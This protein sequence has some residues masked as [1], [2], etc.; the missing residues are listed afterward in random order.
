MTDSK[1][2]LI[3]PACGEFMKKVFIPRT[4]FSVD[5]CTDGCGGIWFDNREELQF[6]EQHESIDEI[7][8]ALNGKVL[9]KTL[10]NEERY[11]PVCA[12][13]LIKNYCSTKQEIEID[14]CYNCGGKFFDRGELTSMRNQYKTEKER[15]E[16]V[17]LI[18]TK[19]AG[20]TLSKQDIE[21]EQLKSQNDNSFLSFLR[22][23]LF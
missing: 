13:K 12:S 5:V 3:C 6:D 18:L 17:N 9:K 10:Y 1:D 11:C 20:A 7:K 15:I 23:L 16:A 8:K 21:L 2:T 4:G 14:E 22:K 19:V